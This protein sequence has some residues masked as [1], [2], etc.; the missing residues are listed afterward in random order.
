MYGST[1]CPTIDDLTG[2]SL[3]PAEAVHVR[4]CPRCQALLREL[5]SRQPRIAPVAPAEL[6]VPLAP[7]SAA[8]GEVYALR[9]PASNE[10]EFALVIDTR[11]VEVAVLAVSEDGS[12]YTESDLALQPSR[13]G[14]AA[15][16][17]QHVGGWV[18]PEQLDA[19]LGFIPLDER[20]QASLRQPNEAA[21]RESYVN[22]LLE[23]WEPFLEPA[24]SLRETETLGELLSLRLTQTGFARGEVAQAAQLSDADLEALTSDKL[25]LLRTTRPE[26]LASV[27]RTLSVLFSERLAERIAFALATGGAPSASLTPAR[28]FGARNTSQPTSSEFERYLAIVRQQMA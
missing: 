6:L 25:D 7:A 19:P 4:D 13:L 20:P 11:E 24:R 22:E 16:V 14:F 9:S 15:V 5:G 17:H 12:R 28:R 23:I 10:L 26:R 2:G 3:E 21:A 8:P 1:L 27:L 18:L